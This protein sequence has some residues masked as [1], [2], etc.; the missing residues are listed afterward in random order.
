MR[1]AFPGVLRFIVAAFIATAAITTFAN[2]KAVIATTLGEIVVEL[3]PQHAPETVANFIDLAENGFYDGLIFHRVVA[4]F[5]IQTG[6]FDESMEYRYPPRKV[7][8]ESFAGLNNERWTIAMAREEH[9]DTADSQFFIN[10][11]DNENLD[12]RP[13]APGYTVFGRVVEGFTNAEDIELVDT[14]I[15]H[16]MANVPIVPV[17]IRGVRIER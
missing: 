10:M 13:G 6:G 9:P 15:L 3:A 2:P 11:A 5:V 12:A 16:G 17:V 4:G 1:K 8:N 14:A 7:I